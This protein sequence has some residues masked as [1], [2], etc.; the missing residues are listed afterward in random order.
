MIGGFQVG[1]FQPAYQQGAA[2]TGGGLNRRRRRRY[3]VEID[4]QQFEVQGLEHARALLDRA[5]ETARSHAQALAQTAVQTA[6]KSGS[7][8]VA[9]PTPTIRSPDPELKPL[10][11]Q[12]RLDMN[13]L[14]RQAAI[15]AELSLLLMRQMQ[16]DDDEETL[17]LLM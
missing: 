14:Y 9:L 8:P 2:A 4:G 1:P 5:K 12:A 11:H 7:K 13:A 3:Y 17:L 6:R 16:D 15:D 10:I